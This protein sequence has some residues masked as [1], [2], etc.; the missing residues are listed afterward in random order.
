MLTVHEDGRL[1][2]GKEAPVNTFCIRRHRHR[3]IDNDEVVLER[4]FRYRCD[5]P[6]RT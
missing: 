2:N 6:V 3:A 1:A 4:Q 5:G